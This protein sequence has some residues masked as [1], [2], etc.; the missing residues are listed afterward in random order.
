MIAFHATRNLEA[1]LREGLRPQAWRSE[2]VADICLAEHPYLCH[3]IYGDTR[4]VLLV[5]ITGLPVEW[6]L[7]E[8]RIFEP[9]EPQRLEV[10]D[11][12]PSEGH[13][14]GWEDPALRT[15]HSASLRRAKE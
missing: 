9:I 4:T 8:G 5:D 2:S 3:A 7:G 1:V 12:Q 14:S 10:M 11:P 15:N 13:W 6:E